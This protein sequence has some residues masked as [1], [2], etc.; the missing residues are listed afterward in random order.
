MHKSKLTSTQMGTFYKEVP[1]V[2]VGLGSSMLC[3]HLLR[4]D[5]EC[6]TTD[7]TMEL[8]RYNYILHKLLAD[9]TDLFGKGGTEHHNL[10]LVRC[11]AENFLDISS[12]IWNKH[13]KV[14]E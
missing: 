4:K 1:S 13:D 2:P 7:L 14:Y 12:H 3:H 5:D 9:R 8:R 10:L 11:H 6:S